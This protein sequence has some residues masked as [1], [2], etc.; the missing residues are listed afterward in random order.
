MQN[1]NIVAGLHGERENMFEF[2]RAVGQDTQEKAM[3]SQSQ[4]VLNNV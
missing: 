2:A 4:S 1:F 3:V